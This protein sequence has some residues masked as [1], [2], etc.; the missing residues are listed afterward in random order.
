M[1][2]R[3]PFALFNSSIAASGR[4]A[5]TVWV[6][7]LAS[8]PP[9]SAMFV[10]G[11]ETFPGT[12]LDLQTWSTSTTTNPISTFVQNN[13][14]T[15][16]AYEAELPFPWGAYTTKSPLVPVGGSV[17]A[18]VEINSAAIT[19][20][21]SDTYLEL[22]TDPSGVYSF[23]NNSVQ[24]SVGA[25]FSNASGFNFVSPGERQTVNGYETSYGTAELDA[26]ALPLS[27]VFVYQIRRLSSSDVQFSL[28]SEDGPNP[29]GGTKI[30]LVG[31]ETMTSI[32]TSAN[33]YV[34]LESIGTDTSYLSVAVN[35][36]ISLD[37]TAIDVPEPAGVSLLSLASLALLAPGQ[38]NRFC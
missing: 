3:L 7:A 16:D 14:L 11:V 9:V 24:L 21:V 5:L 26:S 2:V 38:R 29:G 17:W 12:Q 19:N 6:A 28:Y 10:N 35:Q 4:F 8:A 22:D 30:A 37:Q 20:P 25:S 33:M 27:S 1:A 31:S 32:N 13:S 18:E 36:P 34:S 23:L 15:I